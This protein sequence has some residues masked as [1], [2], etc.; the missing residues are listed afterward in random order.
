MASDG[1]APL[2]FIGTSG[3]QFLFQALCPDR[4]RDVVEDSFMRSNPSS[5]KWI[6][7]DDNFLVLSSEGQLQFEDLNRQERCDADCRFR[8]HSF[9][10]SQSVDGIAVMLVAARAGEDKVVCCS[11]EG[12]VRA[13]ALEVPAQAPDSGHGALFFQKR[14]AGTSNTFMFQSSQRL[15]HFLG[16]KADG[17]VLRLVLHSGTDELDESCLIKVHECKASNVL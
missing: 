17:D 10:S 6:K 14:V 15:S 13:E 4:H 2:H 16:L 3:D 12:E 9:N 1:D 8:I 7:S 5:L 11:Q